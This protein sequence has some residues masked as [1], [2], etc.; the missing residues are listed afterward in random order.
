MASSST[1]V[2]PVASAVTSTGDALLDTAKKLGINTEGK[3]RDE[4]STEIVSK[5]ATS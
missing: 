4:I 1:T 3:T 2:A 5:A